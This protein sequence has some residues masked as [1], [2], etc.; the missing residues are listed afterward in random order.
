PALRAAAPRAGEGG[1]TGSIEDFLRS[2]ERIGPEGPATRPPS[3]EPNFTPA[4]QNDFAAR[5]K[6]SV[7]PAY[8]NANHEPTVTIRGSARVSA[9]P[10]ETIRI[11]G[12]ASDPDGNA[13][14]VRWWRW[15]DVDTYPGEV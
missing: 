7:T 13:V 5:V 6:W 10:G 11:E 2:L 3:P 1:M 14:T 8:A 4:A 12:A 15:K 9:R